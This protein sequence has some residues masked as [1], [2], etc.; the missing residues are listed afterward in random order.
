MRYP[1][2]RI[3]INTTWEVLWIHRDYVFFPHVLFVYTC[4]Y[5]LQFGLTVEDKSQMV[6]WTESRDGRYQL[7]V[8]VNLVAYN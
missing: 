4:M 8:V 3:F 6:D 1:A 2:N 7:D 5:F